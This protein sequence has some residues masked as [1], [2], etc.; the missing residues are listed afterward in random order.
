MNPQEPPETPLD[1]P[2]KRKRS[3]KNALLVYGVILLALVVTTVY[4]TSRW[5]GATE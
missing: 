4:V 3:I 2:P 1:D 5:I